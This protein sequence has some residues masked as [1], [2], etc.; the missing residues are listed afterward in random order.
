MARLYLD[1]GQKTGWCV[2]PMPLLHGVE[3]LKPGRFESHGVRF[4]NFLG[5]LA[6]IERDHGIEEIVYEEVRRH[7]GT[8][9]AHAY[10]GYMAHL[11]S[12]AIQRSIPYR[13]ITVQEVKKAATGKGNAAKADVLAAVQKLGFPVTDENEA[14]AVAIFLADIARR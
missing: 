1:L 3:D 4:V 8:D 7:R 6:R 12:W 2:A 14:D 10:G 5:L 11:Q 9:A 13:S